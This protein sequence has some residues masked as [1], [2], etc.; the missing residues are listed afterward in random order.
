MKNKK[1]PDGWNPIKLGKL[2]TEVS[3]RNKNNNNTPVLSVTNKTGF[4]I[5][6]DYFSKKVFSKDLS[7]YKVIR[8][9]QFAYN[10]SRVNVGSIAC[11]KEYDK[12]LLSPMYVVFEA[13]E[14][15]DAK[16]L[17]YWISSPCFRNLVKA[18]TQG[19]VRDSLNYSSLAG[20]PFLLPPVSEQHKIYG[21]LSSIDAVIDKTQAIIEQTQIFKNGLVQEL[22]TRGIP[23]RY[24]KFKKTEIGV[25]PNGWELKK[26]SEVCVVNPSKKE[27]S[28]FNKDIKVSFIPMKSVQEEGKGIICQYERNILDVETGYT[29]FKN[30]DVLFAKI[31]PCME[32]GKSVVACGLKNGIG[33]GSTEFHVLR[34]KNNVLIPEFLFYYI[35]QKSFRNIAKNYFTGTAGQQRVQSDFFTISKMPIPTIEEQ[36]KIIKSLEGLDN[37]INKMLKEIKNLNNLKYALMQVLLTGKVRTKK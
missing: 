7:N 2:L 22:F 17:D 32:N 13:K 5:S 9:G 21:I 25:T 26:I 20:F 36:V 35:A 23:G 10:P 6:E 31:T 18:G 1:V 30:G 34:V 19:T 27:I 33:F 3:E 37:Y 28:H 24:R 16:Y 8:K 15:L 11:L 14:G 29:Y 4:V 12:G